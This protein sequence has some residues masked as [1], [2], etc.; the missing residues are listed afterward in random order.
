[1]K[2]QYLYGLK[3]GIYFGFPPCCIIR[4]V[5]FFSGS[6]ALDRGVIIRERKRHWGRKHTSQRKIFVPCNVFHKCTHKINTGE[7]IK[8]EGVSNV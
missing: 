3:W 8:V 2:K 7:Y 5:F 4:W 1:M 6:P